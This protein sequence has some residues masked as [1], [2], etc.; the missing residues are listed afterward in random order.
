[1]ECR[2][3]REES[4]HLFKP[5]LCTGSIEYVHRQCLLDWVQYS[6]SPTCSIC[7]TIVAQQKHYRKWIEFT[8]V[9]I[10]LWIYHY[11]LRNVCPRYDLVVLC[12]YWTTV[13][14]LLTNKTIQRIR[15]IP[16]HIIFFPA[17]F[18]YK[19]YS[20]AFQVVISVIPLVMIRKD[21]DITWALL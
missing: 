4:G 15:K 17:V 14:I 16:L 9:S 3:C 6:N 13:Y 2:I 20:V 18:Y 5:C 19:A 12:F 7:G 21:T 8:N 1:M 11:I 10:F